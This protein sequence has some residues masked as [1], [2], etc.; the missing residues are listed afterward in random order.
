MRREWEL[1]DLIECWTLDEEEFA[2]LANKSGATRLGFGLMLKFFELEARFPRRE[3]IPRAAVEFM[4]GQVKVNAK[5]F[6]SYDWS[7]R[8]IEYHRAQIRKFHDFREPTVGDEDKLADWLATK[9]RPVEMPR[10]R[11]RGALLA[12]CREDRIEPPKTTRIERVL[13]AAEAMFERNFT[14]T[15]VQRLSF[16]SV[17]KLKELIVAEAP[18]AGVPVAGED[19]PKRDG[20]TQVASGGRRAFLQK[21][22]EDPGPL[23]LETLLAEIVKL[24]RVKA[25][26][27]PA[28]LF[29]GISEKVVAGWR[30]RA[31][32]MY[33]SDFEAA[34]PPVRLTLLAALCQARQAELIDGLVELLIQ[35]VHK[36]S[37]RAEKKVEGEL[38]A[39]FRRVQG[40]NGILVKLARAALELPEEI[41]RKALY[42]VVGE[43][44]L[45]DIIAEAKANEKELRTRVRTKL[46][47]SYSHHYRRGLPK[48]LKA[49]RFRSSNDTFKPVMD[50]LDLLKRYDGSDADFYAAAEAV[51]LE[52]VVPEDWRDAVLDFDSGLVERISYELCVLVALRKAIRRREIWVEGANTW[53]NPV[54]ICR[55]TSRTTGMCTTRRWP[56]PATRPTSSP[57]CKSGTWR[58]WTG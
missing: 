42:P 21:L 53:R 50:A 29:E 23:Q 26:G 18:P 16:E 19:T 49:V 13:G 10:D 35:L 38:N 55:P 43:R 7:G 54:R 15:T 39:E 31:M 33:P 34:A 6:A 51:P 8:T 57:T 4:A 46:R 17:G 5:L 27:L 22:K 48:L 32:K 40:K 44:T 9:I 28:A 45:E 11:L 47:G 30:A 25:I 36:I 41:V 3:N 20:Q 56:N 1:E 14:A 2:L 58:R 52:H 24:E 37:V 12:R